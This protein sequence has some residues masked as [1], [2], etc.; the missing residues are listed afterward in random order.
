MLGPLLM[1]SRKHSVHARLIRAWRAGGSPSSR[2]ASDSGASG[3]LAAPWRIL[4]S[5]NWT[6][7]VASVSR[8]R[9]NAKTAREN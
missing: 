7:V 6:E 8:I 1:P 2:I 4:A 3:P 5:T 9:A